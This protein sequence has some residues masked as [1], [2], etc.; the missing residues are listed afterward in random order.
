MAKR[1]IEFVHGA[2]F[3][4]FRKLSKRR[5]A[6][7]ILCLLILAILSNRLFT[8]RQFAVRLNQTASVHLPVDATK[9]FRSNR[10]PLVIALTKEGVSEFPQP[11]NELQI[12]IDPATIVNDARVHLKH[13]TYLASQ[14]VFL[15]QS[16][17]NL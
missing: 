16:V 14:S 10:R 2:W 4:F 6:P 7:L 11:R 8:L 5:I 17:L 13:Q 12:K 3:N 15:L 9:P 1:A